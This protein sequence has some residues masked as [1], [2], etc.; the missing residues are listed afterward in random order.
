MIRFMY[1]IVDLSS[2]ILIR[3][4]NI[5]RSVMI[6]SKVTDFIKEYFDQNP[7]SQMGLIVTRNGV[8]E[9]LCDFTGNYKRV[10]QVFKDNFKAAGVPS[11]QNALNLALQSL[12][13]VPSYGSKEIVVIWSSLGT[14]DPGDIF[15]TIE[16]LKKQNIR[17]SVVGLGAEVYI[18]KKLAETTQG[19]YSVPMN[20][21]ML[22]EHLF[23]HASPPPTSVKQKQVLFLLFK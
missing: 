22:K 18:L 13:Q 8:A 7:L 3:D 4:D 19:V 21:S 2:G 5:K 6:D 12:S 11:L 17:C 20:E 23:V 15:K 10:I 16:E 1:L 9:K 14:T